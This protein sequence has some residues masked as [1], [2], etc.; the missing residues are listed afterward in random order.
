MA[1][2]CLFRVV[3]AV[4]PLEDRPR[5]HPIHIFLQDFLQRFRHAVFENLDPV[6]LTRV[7]WSGL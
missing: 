3:Q 1:C 2:V 6:P 4:E 7:N 5:R